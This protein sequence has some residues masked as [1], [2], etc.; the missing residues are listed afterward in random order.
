M[1]ARPYLLI[2]MKLGEGPLA[3]AAGPTRPDAPM[4]DSIGADAAASAR[5]TAAAVASRRL[6]PTASSA[7]MFALPAARAAGAS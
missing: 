6:A 1:H 2:R 3:A 5:C 7:S 4:R